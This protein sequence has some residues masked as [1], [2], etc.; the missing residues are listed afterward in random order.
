[1]W[2]DSSNKYIK[3]LTDTIT[4]GIGNVLVKVIQFLLMPLYTGIMTTQEYGIAE[5]T[6][7]FVE[8]VIPIATVNISTAVF[9]FSVDKNCDYKQLISQ[10]LYVLILGNL[11]TFVFVY[12]FQVRIGLYHYKIFTLLLLFESLRLCL[13]SFV[14][15]IGHVRRFAFGGVVSVLSLCVFNILLLVKT[16]LGVDGYLYSILASQIITCVYYLLSSKINS[17]II[18]TFVDYTYIAKLM[19]FSAPL[20]LNSVSWWLI[21]ISGRYFLLWFQ[22]SVAAG[23]YIAASKLPSLINIVTSIFQQAW[24]YATARHARSSDGNVFFINVFNVYAFAVF[25]TSSLFIFLSP[26]VGKLLLKKD[27]IPGITLLPLLMYV[28]ILN[29]FSAFLGTF[30]NAYKKNAM[31]F[32]ST[33]LG[34]VVTIVA[35]YFSVKHYASVGIILSNIMGYLVI[36]LIRIYD[37]KKRFS[38]RCGSKS[39][40]AKLCLVFFQ[41]LLQSY[42]YTALSLV[43]F[44]IISLWS[45]V[46]IFYDQIVRLLKNTL[47]LAT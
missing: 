47:R 15:G 36:V 5:I 4:F 30:Y 13:S 7:N 42:D 41:C 10:S 45:L 31:I 6:Q 44:C 14:R 32:L 21:N 19:Q 3:L 27:F 33:L 46:D 38:I 43:L 25:A 8:L 12:F 24:Q 28:A 2:Y 17:Y 22:G 26:Y 16:N 35:G 9:R 34:T 23:I 40:F 29:S 11:I 39:F 20:V 37:V 1:M 18:F